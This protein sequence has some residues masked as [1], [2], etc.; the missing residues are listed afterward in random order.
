MSKYITVNIIEKLLK[1][2]VTF[3]VGVARNQLFD[4]S[5]TDYFVIVSSFDVVK[6]KKTHNFKRSKTYR[7]LMEIN[8]TTEEIQ[9]FKDN[10]DKFKK[11]L[12]NNYGKIYELKNKSFKK[13]L[14]Y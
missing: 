11:V 9:T 14:N 5:S 13:S 10:T 6:Y 3:T 8:L 4:Y 7:H 12:Q 2:K 1:D